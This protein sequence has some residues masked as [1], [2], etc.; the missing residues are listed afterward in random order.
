[1]TEYTELPSAVRP[2]GGLPF[3]FTGQQFKMRVT[4][5]MLWGDFL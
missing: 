5:R 1:M 4:P 3:P 2:P